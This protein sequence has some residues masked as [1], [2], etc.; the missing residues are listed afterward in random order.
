M[1]D[2]LIEKRRLELEGVLRVLT[3]IDQKL[4]SDP[5]IHA[6]LTY[7]DDKWADFKENPSPYIDSFWALYSNLPDL[8]KD[9]VEIQ[10]KGISRKFTE[11]WKKAKTEFGPI[12]EPE[13]LRKDAHNVN[14]DKCLEVLEKNLFIFQQAQNEFEIHQK[15]FNDRCSEVSNTSNTLLDI[16]NLLI[17]ESDRIKA[18][19][20]QRPIIEPKELDDSTLSIRR[21][22]QFSEQKKEKSTLIYTES[23]S[24]KS[25]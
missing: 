25:L 20:K 22:K 1:D 11:I 14:F 8:K 6:F 19:E 17:R 2:E 13:L 4:Q 9:I 23:K 10:K 18:R 16:Q 5:I 7:S 12:K 15:L 21:I 24:L 3:Q